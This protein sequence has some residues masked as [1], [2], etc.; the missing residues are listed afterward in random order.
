MDVYLDWAATAVP[1]KEI[2]EKT[3]KT[4]VEVFGNP[5]SLHR[6]GTAAGKLLEE[7]RK[8]V[9]KLLELTKNIFFLLRGGQNPTI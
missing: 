8:D 5:S 3:C 4:A 2:I 9:R 1:D 7:S 6:A